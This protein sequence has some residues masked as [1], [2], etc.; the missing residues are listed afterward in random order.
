MAEESQAP[1]PLVEEEE[2]ELS[3]QYDTPLGLAHDTLEAL[4]RRVKQH[5]DLASE[6]Y[7]RLW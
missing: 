1:K 6:Y 4:K 5:Y 7:L 3:K 2:S